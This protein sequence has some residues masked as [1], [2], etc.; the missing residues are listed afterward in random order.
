MGH[1]FQLRFGLANYLIALWSAGEWDGIEPAR[2]RCSAVVEDS[3]DD[4]TTLA[5]TAMLAV[6]RGETPSLLPRA[7]WSAPGTT[8]PAWRGCGSTRPRSTWPTATSGRHWPRGWPGSSCRSRVTGVWDDLTHLW[9]PAADLAVRLGDDAAVARL[10][11]LTDEGRPASRAGSRATASCCGP[12]SLPVT[13]G[14]RRPSSLRPRAGAL[15]GLGVGPLRRPRPGPPRPVAGDAGPSRRGRHAPGRRAI[16]VRDAGRG[17][18]AGRPRRPRRTSSDLTNPVVEQ[19][20]TQRASSRPRNL[21]PPGGRA[22]RSVVEQRAQR[23][24]SRPRDPG[25]LARPRLRWWLDR[26]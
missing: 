11:E 22:A 4:E 20:A 6:V 18:L 24:S 13:G 9:G 14:S 21:A 26:P 12:G 10:V 25:H 23:A 8:R 1:A 19:R 5:L 17:R 3:A 2:A 15:P 7:R 16:D